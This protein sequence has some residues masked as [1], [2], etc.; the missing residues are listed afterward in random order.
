MASNTVPYRQVRAQ[1]DDETITVYQAY[2]DDIGKEAVEKQRLDASPLFKCSRTTWVKPSWAWM[3]YRAGYSYKDNRQAR[4]LA[5]KMKHEDFQN[6]LKRGKLTTHGPGGQS[7]SKS[8][9]A[10]VN[11]QWDPERAPNMDKLPYRSIQIGIPGVVVTEWVK[12]GI[13]S[14]EDV[15]DKARKLKAAVD[16]DSKIS[17]EDLIKQGLVPEEKPYELPIEIQNTLQMDK[18][19]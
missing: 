5:L 4:I 15:T 9:E 3:M 10:V 6:L 2:S 17:L 8:D 12:N 1:Y 16:Q 19:D 11:I 18:R 14:I 7:N 13:V